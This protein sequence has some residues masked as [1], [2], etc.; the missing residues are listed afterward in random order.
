MKHIFMNTRTTSQENGTQVT[1]PSM[2]KPP[3]SVRL[4]G[5]V[6]RFAAALALATVAQAATADDFMGEYQGTFFPD[7][8][9]KLEAAA[10]VVAEGDGYYR[11][12]VTAPGKEGFEGASVEIYGRQF[13]PEVGLF[14]RAGGYH[15]NGNIKNGTLIANSEYGQS[16][17]LNKIESKSPKAALKPPEGAVV[18]L[19]FKPGQPPDLSQWTNREWKALDN[20]SMQC[21]PG[22]GENRTQREFGRLEHLHLEFWLPLEPGNRGQGRA[23]SGVYLAD[24]YEVQ[25]LDSFGLTHTS[26]D[27][28]GL[29]GIARARVN[30]SLPPETWQTY[31]ITFQPAQ[32]DNDGKVLEQPKITVLHNGIK[33]HERQEIP[34]KNH[35]L[36][37]PLQL[38]DHGHPIPFRNIWL[39]EGK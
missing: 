30:A 36:K 13:G 5:Q 25:V 22:K 29:Y 6:R 4:Y 11:I 12:V 17:R 18:L 34:S 38:Q 9:V 39:V 31:D 37:G 10:K 14:G 21:A 35:R 28:G 7:S 20:G 15:W 24:Q 2:A 16:F 26:G 33:I 3:P 27:C 32:L 19:P 1:D 23:N 8:T